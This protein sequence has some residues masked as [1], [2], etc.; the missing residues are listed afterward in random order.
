MAGRKG[1]TSMF[2]LAY[3][4]WKMV[5]DGLRADEK[6]RRQGEYDD[7]SVAPDDATDYTHRDTAA[8]GG[9]YYNES[10]DNLLLTRTGTNGTQYHDANAQYAACGLRT[11]NAGAALEYSEAEEGGVR[12]S[13]SAVGRAPSAEMIDEGCRSGREE[14]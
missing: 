6:G 2:D 14:T 5:E 13:E 9:A 12:G 11:P 7:E 1:R 10:N 3:Y 8:P 4:A